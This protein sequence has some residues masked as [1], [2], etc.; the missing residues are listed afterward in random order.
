MRKFNS[1]RVYALIPA[2]GGSK[3]IHRKNIALLAGKPLIKYTIEAA[4]NATWVDEVWVSSDDQE[5]LKISAASGT[6]TLLRPEELANDTASA[7]EVVRHFIDSLPPK[8]YDKNES[9]IIYLQPTSPLRNSKHIDE[10]LKIM[11]QLNSQSIISVVE[12]DKPPQKAFMINENGLLQSLFTEQMSNERRQDLTRCYYPNGAIYAFYLNKFLTNNGFP[13][14]GAT[15][16]IMKRSESIDIDN[17]DDLV[18]AK[19]ALGEKNERI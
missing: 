11:A 15:P 1:K 17:A 13:S 3:G 5:I 6:Q 10:S 9:I 12:A 7:V 18:L 16:F 2:R 4:L 19:N 14:N 8:S